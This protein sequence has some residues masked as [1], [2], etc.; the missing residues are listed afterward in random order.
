[1]ATII[2][3]EEN[4]SSENFL[5]CEINVYKTLDSQSNFALYQLYGQ[6][7]TRAADKNAIPLY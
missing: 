2:C 6:S 3:E 1:M 7:L 4:F 5:I